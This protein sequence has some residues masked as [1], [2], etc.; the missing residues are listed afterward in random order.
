MTFLQ[1]Q[2]IRKIPESAIKKYIKTYLQYRGWFIFHILQGVGSRRGVSDFIAVKDGR[3]LFLEVKTAT[4]RQSSTR[5]SSRKTLSATAASISL[6]VVWTM[7]R[8]M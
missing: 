2:D 3:V 4:G 8:V 7:S 5:S 1:R 6:F